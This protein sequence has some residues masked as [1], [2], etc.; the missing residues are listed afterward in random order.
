MGKW[1]VL[2]PDC[3]IRLWL[4]EGLPQKSHVPVAR[5]LLESSGTSIPI[6]LCNPTDKSIKLYRTT[7]VGMMEEVEERQV[8]AVSTQRDSTSTRRNCAPVSPGKN[9]YLQCLENTTSKHL[10]TSQTKALTSLLLKY[11][12]IFPTPQEPL[13][14]TSK[15]HLSIDTGSAHRLR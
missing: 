10:T 3:H 12:D 13:G 2:V 5:S 6:Q 8:G 11:S 14:H 4:L 9:S 15:L 7:K 1:S